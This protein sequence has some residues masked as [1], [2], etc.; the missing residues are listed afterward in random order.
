MR[1]L[2][3]DQGI[4]NFGY[5]VLEKDDSGVKLVTYGCF[6]TKSQGDQQKR[7]YDL[8]TNFENLVIEFKPDQ[9]AHERLFFSPPGKNMR[10]KSASILNTNMITGAIWYIAGKHNIPVAQYSPQSVCIFS[11]RSARWSVCSSFSTSG[12]GYA[13]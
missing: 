13:L 7:I 12:A 2:S 6:V 1:I 11:S 10:K 5:A 8:I 4:A 9:I 3:I